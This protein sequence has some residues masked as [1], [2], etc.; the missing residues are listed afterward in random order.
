MIDE[1]RAA[2]EVM[3][4][5]DLRNLNDAGGDLE[6]RDEQGATPVSVFPAAELSLT[7]KFSNPS[8]LALTC[9]TS[10]FYSRLVLF[11]NCQA[12]ATAKYAVM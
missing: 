12:M 10:S 11:S 1:T 7:E 2:N 4:L 5:S 3:M 6:F 8:L 9:L